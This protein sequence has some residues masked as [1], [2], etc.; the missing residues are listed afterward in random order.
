MMEDQRLVTPTD[1]GRDSNDHRSKRRVILSRFLRNILIGVGIAILLTCIEG[2]LWIINPLHLFGSGSS[3]NVSSLLSNLAHT[4]LLWLLL[5]LQVIAVCALLL[6]LDKPLALRRYVRDVQKAQEQYRTLY[7]PLTSW[8]AIYETSL[9]CYQDA[10]D[11]ST[12]GK[13]RHISVLELAQELVD[14]SRVVRSHQLILGVPG[15][16]KSVMLYFYLL[17]ALRRSRSIIFGRDKIPIYV[18]MH[19]YNLYLDTHSTGAP[20]EEFVLGTQSLLNFLYSS[21]LVGMNHLRPF[22]HRLVAQGNILFLCDGLNEI[23]EKYRSAV[24]VEFAELMGQNQNQFVL[25]CRE[26][27][28]QQQPQLAQAVI[29]NLVV[30]VYINPLDE[31][32]ER[33]FVERYIKEQ[34]AGKKWRH[35]AGQVMEVIN[36]S[37]LRDHCTNPFM[38]F[39]LMEIIDGVG[40][41][42]G[43]KLDTRGQLL[44]AFVKHLIQH[45][46]SQ[47]QWSNETLAEQDIV[48]FLSELACAARWMN[49]SNAIQIPSVGKKRGLELEDLAGGLQSWLSEHPAQCPITIESV[50]RHSNS[51]SDSYDGMNQSYTGTLHKPYSQEELIQLVRFAQSASFIEISQSGIIS[52]RHELIAAYFVAE[53]FVASGEADTMKGT[54]GALIDSHS[55]QWEV[56]NQFIT[57]IALWAGLLDEP[58]EYAQKFTALGQRNPAFNVEALALAFVCI[59]VAYVP[60]QAE[61]AHQLELP[62]GLAETVAV[63]VQDKQSCDLLAHFFTR[64]ALE[65]AQ[66]I[67]QSLFPLLMVDGIDEMIVRL[68]AGVVLE[69]LFNQLCVVVDNTEYEALVKRLVRILGHFRAVGIPRATELSQPS[70]ERSG[71]LRSAAINILGGTNERDAV[72]PLILC[73]RDSNQ[74]IVGRSANALIRLGPELSFTR[75]VQELEDRTPTSAREQVHWTVLHILERFQN[76]SDAVRQLTPSQHLRLVSVLLHVLTT[77]YAPEDQQ[78][79]R[80]MLVKQARDAGISPAGERAVEVLV[81]NLASDKD[82]MARATL[83]TLKEVGTP[84]TPYLLEQLKPQTP[85]TMRIRIVEVLADVQDPRALPYLLHS[86]D[87]PALVVQQQVALALRTF[88]PE[89]ISG[90]IDCVLHNDSELVATRAEQ[91]L[92]DIGDEATT[93]LIQSLTPIVPGRTHLLVQVLERIRNPQAIPALI[94]FLENSQQSSQVD[95]SLQVAVVHALGQFPDERVVAPLLEMLASSNPLIY[96]GAINALSCLEDVALDGLIAALNGESEVRD[97]KEYREERGSSEDTQSGVLTSRIERAILGMVRF[98]GER[99]LEVLGNGSDTQAQHTIN[100]F[101]AKG[102]EG[103][104]VLVRNLFHSNTRL[105]NYARLILEEMNGQIMVPALLEVLDHPEPAW[106][107]VITTLLLKHPREAIPPLVSLLDDDERADAAQVILLEF[108]PIV[109]P[110]VVTGLDALNNRAQGHARY[111]VVTLVQQTPELVYEVVQLFNLNPPQRAHEA[112]IDVLTN[113]LAS[114]SVPALLEGLED[115]HLIGATSEA[116]KRLVN[117]NDVLSDM[118]MNELLSALRMEQRKHGAGITLVEIGEKAV[119][120]VGNLITDP[121]PAVAQIAQNIL[122]EMGVA[123]FSFIWAAYSNTTNRDR[124]TAARSIFR[125]M[126]TVVIKDELVHLLKSNDPDDLS[127]ALALLIE[128]INDETMQAD[129]EHEMVPALL[130]HVQTHSDERASHRIVALLLLLG[131]N[132]VIEHMTDV[133]YNY[134]NHE[135]ILVYAFL[136]LG[137]EGVEALLEIL[138]DPETP[139]L[140]R[141]EV[142]SLSGIMA[143]N[144]DIREYAS[145]LGEYGLWAGQSV[146]MSDVLHPDRLAVSLRALG[147]L[148]TGGHWDVTE[149]QK[150]RL[151][152]HEH[153]FERE[154]YDILLG[155]RYGPQITTL[156]NDLQHEREEHKQHIMKFSQEIMDLHAQISDLEE[157]LEH[158]RQE[159]GFRGVELDQANKTIEELQRSLKLVTQEK[160]S[161]QDNVQGATQERQTLRNSLQEITREKD[162]LELQVSQWRH[163]ADQLEQGMK[164]NR[165]QSHKKK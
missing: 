53:Y 27:D 133:L 65:G 139:T 93:D 96:E 38:F 159:H 70:P 125:R 56:G 99:L 73:L 89:S 106:R 34:D 148:L 117:K 55:D 32:H 30:R 26:V 140:L 57:P 86:L 111:I 72:E 164:L 23:D 138:Y 71:R 47:P 48:I 100:I 60:P 50:V 102:I 74:S 109:L 12:P 33:R 67:Y 83:K 1:M 127:M 110:Y 69:L 165:P 128:R 62:P 136:L 80:E 94:A 153:S 15:A 10:P 142:A 124:R 52:F 97:L 154:L 41:N 28:F 14:S 150:L 85:E 81:Q 59:G 122:C 7:T 44:R 19:R 5:L 46:I 118:V 152:S 143:P 29:E 78:K 17:I 2:V 37:R 87:D 107:A 155:W 21:D 120:G 42:R 9:T 137:D 24:N 20:G 95:Q 54:S 160:Q 134:P 40:V 63:V 35:T 149:L 90:L 121:D 98:P 36:R 84:A 104:Q 116:L 91:I 163:Y 13:V 105:Q 8:S 39:S 88:A 11:L 144:V 146:G 31:K 145:M 25:T 61:G 112:L 75:L 82:T 43:K 156:E 103:A 162:A 45:E 49:S 115:A 113:Q 135:Q 16:G 4:P 130:D 126:R 101:L 141:A 114:E 108:G 66:D 119:P 92:G 68:N 161:M 157:Q 151:H 22:L 79:A 18:P 132:V 131:G 76:E 77:N 147:G 51:D 58:E 123:A 6:F 3:H 64:F 129:R 158:I